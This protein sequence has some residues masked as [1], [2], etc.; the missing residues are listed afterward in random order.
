MAFQFR[1]VFGFLGVCMHLYQ[2]RASMCASRICYSCVCARI[3]QKIKISWLNFSLVDCDFSVCLSLALVLSLTP[4]RP[5][6]FSRT[7]LR[8]CV[9]VYVCVLQADLPV[10]RFFQILIRSSRFSSLPLSLECTALV[11]SV[12]PALLA[13][14]SPVIF[15]EQLG[16][17]SAVV[18]SIFFVPPFPPVHPPPPPESPLYRPL[19]RWQM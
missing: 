10:Y 16:A 2:G 5:L 19:C 13:W 15:R 18:C 4:T 11:L 6:A 8:A 3:K 9:C 14:L 17:L 12:S 7:L 1:F